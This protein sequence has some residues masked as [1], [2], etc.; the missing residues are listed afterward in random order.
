MPPQHWSPVEQASPFWLQYDDALHTCMMQ[1][2]EQ[3]SALVAQALPRV[4][5]VQPMPVGSGTQVPPV[6]LPLQHDAF[7]LHALLSEMQAGRLQTPP[8]HAPEQHSAG[9]M[10]APP[11]CRQPV[12]PSPKPMPVLVL[13]VLAVPVDMVPDIVPDAAPVALPVLAPPVAPVVLFPLELPQ[14]ATAMPPA[15]IAR[16]RRRSARLRR[17]IEVPFT[18]G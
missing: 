15:G 7:E 13:P 4:L 9:C 3:Q 6:Q 12:P 16:A 1:S 2:C 14:P 5:P 10:H 8:V 18:T 17:C 11:T